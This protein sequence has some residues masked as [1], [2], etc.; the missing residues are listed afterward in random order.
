M[1]HHRRHW[2]HLVT[3][4]G[5]IA[6]SAGAGDA[7]SPSAA[8]PAPASG[9][10]TPFMTAGWIAPPARA[11]TNGALPLFRKEF[12]VDAEPRQATL[13]IV[14]LGDYDARVN[15]RRL[16]D[17]GINQPWSQ[18]ERTL[19]YR[20][21]DLS[22]L[23][24]RGTNCVGVML[25][26]SFWHNPNPPKGRY[27]K[28]GPQRAAREPLLLR[29]EVVLEHGA[30]PLQR[31]GTDATWRVSEGPMVFSHL[32]AGEDFDAR[33]DQPGWDGPR[34]DDG[35][36]LPA[37]A[38]AA[39]Q[40]DLVAQDW[41]PIRAYKD[42]TPVSVREA[43][44]GTWLYSFPQ[45]CAAQLRVQVTGGKPGDR[46]AFRC[47]EHKS[48]EERLFGHY[49]VGGDL[50]TDGQPLVHQWVSFY[51]GMQF[52]EV[53]GAVPEGR[54]NPTGLPVIQTLALVP[55]RTGLPE[56][57][58]F[59]CS[60][61]LF[62]GTHRIIDW[63]MQANS[64]HVLTD[65]PHREKLG[66]LEVAYLMAPSFQYRYDCGDWFNKILRDIRD[67][68]EPGGR[69]LTVA[70][71]Y[72]AGR[73]PDQFNWT[74]E[75]GAAAVLLPWHQYEWSGDPRVLRENFDMM[76][77]FTDY[78]QT[79]AKDGLA[80][81]GLGDWYDYGHGK[82]P[83][84]SRFTPPELSA[85]ATWA[86]CA[87]TVARAAEILGLPG[88]T[89]HYREL[90]ARIAA[91][92][93]RHFRDPATGKLKHSGSPQCANAMALCAD[94]VPRSDRAALVEEI[95]AD[96]K[97]RN[98]QQTPGDVGHVYFIRALAE[99]G[100]S[101]VLH[102]VY[103]RDGLG[104]YGGILKKGLTSLPETWDA[105]MDGYQSLNHCMLGHVIEWFYG[106]VAGIRPQ[107]GTVGWKQVLIAPNPGPLSR[108]ASKLDT[109]RGRIASRWQVRDGEFQLEV[110][111]PKAVTATAV[112]PSGDTKSLRSGL[113][114]ITEPWRPPAT[115]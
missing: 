26:N 44:P 16:A 86:L 14:G 115:N 56:V 50:I 98:W 8:Q 84:P 89:R 102:R 55:V 39:P 97:T 53:S 28:D 91:D 100:R 20:D 94:V 112:L 11:V 2:S 64:S 48:K 46:I 10:A 81:G 109:P 95:V 111:I 6:M 45:N 3:L 35:G 106:Y 99:A 27:N 88:E 13:R 32:F 79:A 7:N 68:Q 52:V 75:W 54:P 96:L 71:S 105:M 12:I 22:G 40:A 63:A 49:T 87:R 33:R 18:Y 62:N 29:A 51:L 43:E 66:W 31:I 77:R 104:S 17:T 110:D 82:P 74:V 67:A 23:V 36:W 65:C 103:A 76:R 80:P 42:F 85:T 59:E 83:G 61:E 4:L 34:F 57:G 69:V 107:P 72:P 1:N 93:Q 30:G 5:L 101:E 78:L 19:Y 41:P 37:R 70:P 90:H 15:G 9:T 47:G 108:A 24:R 58:S 73:F 21:F 25:A 38:A 60:S 113:Q 92:F 114:R